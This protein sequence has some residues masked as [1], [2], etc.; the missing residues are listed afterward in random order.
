VL[1]DLI[2]RSRPHP[3][4]GFCYCIGI[5]GLVGQHGT[6]RFGAACARALALGPTLPFASGTYGE[7][8]ES[9]SV[10]AFALG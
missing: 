3:E 5:L 9:A 8:D 7:H 6:E 2:L 1:L 4:Q 10:V